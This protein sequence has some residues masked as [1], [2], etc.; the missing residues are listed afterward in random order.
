MKAPNPTRLF[1]DEKL[2][3][4]VAASERL[5]TTPSAVRMWAHR[6]RVPRGV[7]PDILEAYHNVTIGDLKALEGDPA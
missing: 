7:W 1:V 3:G 6:K 4:T 5:K 2:G